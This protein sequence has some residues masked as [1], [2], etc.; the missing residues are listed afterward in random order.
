MDTF[1][2]KNQSCKISRYCILSMTLNPD[3]EGMRNKW[4][5]NLLLETIIPKINVILVR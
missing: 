4:L 5:Y 2:E 1:D 3:A